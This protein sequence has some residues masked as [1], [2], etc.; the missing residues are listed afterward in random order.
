VY[1]E[2]HEREEREAKGNG[3]GLMYSPGSDISEE[4]A[5]ANA[6]ADERGASRAAE[7]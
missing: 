5:A 6:L 7:K 4:M 2:L 1:A 3:D